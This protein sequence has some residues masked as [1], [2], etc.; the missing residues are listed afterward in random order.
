MLEWYTAGDDYLAMM[1]QCEQ[2]FTAVVSD[3]GREAV[4]SYQGERIDLTP[5]WER[6][7]VEQAF[8]LFASTSL[9]TSLDKGKGQRARGRGAGSSRIKK[10]RPQAA[11]PVLF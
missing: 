2:M 7:T 6:M 3:L 4:L 10:G 11:L 8:E 9:E 5:P 1:K